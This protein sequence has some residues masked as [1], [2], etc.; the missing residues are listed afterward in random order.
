MALNRCDVCG[1]L[2][3]MGWVQWWIDCDKRK[4][5][6]RSDVLMTYNNFVLEGHFANGKFYGSSG[7]A[8]TPGYCSCEEYEGITHWTPLPLP[9]KD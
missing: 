2:W 8:H 5:D 9:P 1:A 4:P 7:C 6:E 3:G